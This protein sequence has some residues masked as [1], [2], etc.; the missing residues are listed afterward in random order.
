MSATLE[1]MC[2]L[3]NKLW[4]ARG[5]GHKASW[6]AL[7]TAGRKLT[8]SL[9]FGYNKARSYCREGIRCHHP[10]VWLHP[11]KFLAQQPGV[12]SQHG[13]LTRLPKLTGGPQRNKNGNF[14]DRAKTILISVFKGGIFQNISE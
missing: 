6:M 8:S 5:S 10:W 9:G 4:Q 14:C 2:A 12:T 3:E 7:L 1:N 13:E 11:G